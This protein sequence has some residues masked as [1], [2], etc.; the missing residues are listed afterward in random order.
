MNTNERIKADKPI[1][2]WETRDGTWKWKVFKKYQK[3]KNEATNPYARWFCGV[4]SPFTYGSD[5][6]GDVYVREI[7]MSAVQ[8][9]AE[10]I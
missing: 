2:I 8:T 7:K 9:Y 3:P 6:L 1:E 4:S 5:E 10:V